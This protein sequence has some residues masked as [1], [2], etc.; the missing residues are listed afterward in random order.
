M[1]PV[2]QHDLQLR[3]T[4]TSAATSAAAASAGPSDADLPGRIGD[5][6]DGN[7][8]SAATSATASTR[9]AGRARTLSFV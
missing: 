3:A 4:T 8:P 7:V 9:N 1:E 5:R 6:S 2:G